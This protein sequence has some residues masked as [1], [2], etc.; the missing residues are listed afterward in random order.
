MERK[1]KKIHRL[2]NSPLFSFGV[3]I[4][5]GSPTTAEVFT[6]LQR[7]RPSWLDLAEQLT[8]ATTVVP[9]EHSRDGTVRSAPHCV[10]LMFHLGLK[11]EHKY[12][13][14]PIYYKTVFF[15]PF[16]CSFGDG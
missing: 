12:L 9:S 1:T 10:S 3:R 6:V 5:V 2:G 13:N 8:A 15:C 11:K 4:P 14:T 7:R 16:S